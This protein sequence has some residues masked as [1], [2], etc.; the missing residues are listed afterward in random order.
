MTRVNDLELAS[1]RLHVSSCSSKWD[2][3]L[4]ASVPAVPPSFNGIGKHYT[5]HNEA[6]TKSRHRKVHFAAKKLIVT[7]TAG[8]P[9]SSDVLIIGP[10]AFPFH[11]L[12]QIKADHE[13]V[14][15]ESHA[16]TMLI[17]A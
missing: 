3:D 2:R 5:D 17:L 12:L 14:T 13:A 11:S 1:L 4:S 15:F 9:S 10:I 7:S 6:Q 16:M 8:G